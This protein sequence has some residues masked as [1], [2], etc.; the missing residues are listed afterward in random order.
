MTC[1]DRPSDLDLLL[2]GEPVDDHVRAHAEACE[3][4]AE[5]VALD[6]KITSALRSRRAVTA[7]P[8]LVAAAL[9]EA[10]REAPVSRL[11]LA[12]SRPAVRVARPRRLRIAGGVLAA[13]LVLVALWITRDTADLDLE[14]GDLTAEAPASV[15]PSEPPAPEIV[16]PET[17]AP[18]ATVPEARTVAPRRAVAARPP[19][20]AATP[21]PAPAPTE[22][23][24]EPIAQ[25]P[26][27]PETEPS[28]EEIARAEADL[29]LAFALVGEAQT[30]ARR[31]VTASADA[32]TPA[33]THAIPFAP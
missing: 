4:C 16:L 8:G 18:E 19:R 31:A 1:P 10:R 27:P 14:A 29:K 22:A 5:E 20:R 28:A 11:G 26:P 23:V 7:P 30:R 6:A 12:A 15:P 13:G 25:A 32:V 9:A 17:T 3:T 33:L 21:P 24:P 2:A